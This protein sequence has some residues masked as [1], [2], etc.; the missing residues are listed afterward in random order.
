LCRYT[1]G[2][3]R[4]NTD[5]GGGTGGSSAAAAARDASSPNAAAARC[6]A[7]AWHPGTGGGFIS[8]HADGNAYAYDA[9]RDA[10]VDPQFPPLK[11]GLY[12]SNPAVP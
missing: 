4:F 11:V 9:S 10:S 5:G 8:L 7:V 12:K 1:A 6:H 2:T 3:L